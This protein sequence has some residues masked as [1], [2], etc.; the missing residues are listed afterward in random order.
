M[1]INLSLL[2][3]C[4]IFHLLVYRFKTHLFGGLFLDAPN[5]ERKIHKFPTYLI[6]GH[7]VFFSYVVYY[8]LSF[9]YNLNEKIIYL[10]IL[11][12]IFFIGILDDLKNLK[13]FNKLFMILL[14]YLTLCFFDNNYLLTEI[15][16]E[17]FERTFDFGIYSY[18]ISSLCVLLL[19]NSINLIDGINGLAMMIF[20]I[21][22]VYLNYFLNLDFNIFIL[23]FFL[24]IF[25]NI[26]KG[27][28]F[29]GNSGSL[30]IGTIIALSTIKVYNIRIIDKYSAEDIFIL[31]LLPGLDMFRLFVE[32]ILKKKHPF[33][34]DNLHLHHLLIKKFV[35]EKVLFFYFATIV[36]SSLLA[37]NDYVPE[38][39]IIILTLSIYLSTLIILKK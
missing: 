9:D 36:I 39:I 19:I 2:L 37:F 21:I 8:L 7:F 12:I 6:G 3:L 27:N 14:A 38:L 25:F 15:Y 31:F 23:I 24:F 5:S 26:Y 33:K 18:L 16:F 22:V 32:R 17:T 30:L 20:I 34:A 11:L 35:L 28:Y 13:P 4:I 1:S 10:F 29:L